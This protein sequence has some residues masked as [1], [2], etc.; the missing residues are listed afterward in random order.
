MNRSLLNFDQLYDQYHT[1]VFRFSYWLSGNRED[2]K[3][4]CS[5]TFI[6]LWTAKTDIKVDTVKAYLFAIA[7]N[8]Y[9]QGLRKHRTQVELDD[10]I[11]DERPNS[12]VI[13]QDQSELSLVIK[14]LQALP[15]L[16]RTVLIMKAY[17]GLS[18]KDMSGLLHLSVPALKIKVHRARV[19]LALANNKRESL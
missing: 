18:Y 3:D 8:I 10:E 7:R 1:D 19:K 11:A 14:G 6:R 16:E 9:L 15:E 2:A 12:D 4:I 17:E 5:E 13:A